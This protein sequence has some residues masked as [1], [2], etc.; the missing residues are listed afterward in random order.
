MKKGKFF[1]IDRRTW[2]AVCDEGSVNAAVSYLVLAQGT[3]GNNRSTAWSVNALKTYAGIS[4]PR[5]RDAVEHLLRLGFIR[6]GEN[7]SQAKPRYDL[8]SW[9]QVGS[10]QYSRKVSDLSDYQKML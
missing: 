3:A 1:A 4:F 2:A 5:G 10:Q 9:A 7:H 6:H 8:L